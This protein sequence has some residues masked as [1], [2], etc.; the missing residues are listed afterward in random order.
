MTVRVCV[1][2]FQN[3][4]FIVEF[5]LWNDERFCF[6]KSWEWIESFDD[7]SFYFSRNSFVLVK[8]TDY[9]FISFLI[10]FFFFRLFFQY[11][12]KNWRFSFCNF[13]TYSAISYRN[14]LERVTTDWKVLLMKRKG[15]IIFLTGDLSLLRGTFNLDFL[16]LWTSWLWQWFPWRYLPNDFPLSCGLL[17]LLWKNLDDHFKN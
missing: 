5:L 8:Y 10:E 16:I 14:W 13:W 17:Y 9:F 6:Q 15:K 3:Q 12:C 7:F 4:R 1:F 11:H 2:C